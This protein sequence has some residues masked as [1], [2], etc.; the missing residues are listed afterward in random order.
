LNGC[1]TGVTYRVLV[2]PPCSEKNLQIPNAFT[3][4]G[5][6]VNDVFEAVPHEGFEVVHSLN[7]FNRWGEKIFSE[8]G[9]NARWDGKIDGVPA[10]SD[11]YIWIL[12]VDCS[13]SLTP[14]K[15]NVTLLR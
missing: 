1:E 11:V 5:D 7:I 12:E 8:T 14:V 4:N 3:P 15:G 10:P 2:F 13:G 9:A 6:S